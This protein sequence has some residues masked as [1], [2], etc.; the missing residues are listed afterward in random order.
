MTKRYYYDDKLAVEWMVEH[1]QMKF[2]SGRR[3][4]LYWED[5]NAFCY[6]KNHWGGVYKKNRNTYEGKF[7]LHP[8]SLNILEPREMDIIIDCD[9]CP[10]LVDDYG[11]HNNCAIDEAKEWM[12]KII[13]R[14]SVLFHWPKEK[15]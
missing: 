3:E 14:N 9:G 10:W 2:A 12:E 5:R 11:F 4:V 8:D 1:F 13:Q 15:V 7:Y 6:K